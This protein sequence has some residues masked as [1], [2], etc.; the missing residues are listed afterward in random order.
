MP[1]V[2]AFLML[3]LLACLVGGGASA[4]AQSSPGEQ[5][6]AAGAETLAADAQEET[7]RELAPHERQLA[8]IVYGILSFSHWPQPMPHRVLCVLGSTSYSPI[9]AAEPARQQTPAW[10]VRAVRSPAANDLLYQTCDAMY[11]GALPD[12]ENRALWLQMQGRPVVTIKE[13]S[14]YCDEGALFCLYFHEDG[15]IGFQ[16]NLDAVARSGIRVD[17]Q[18]LKLAR[19][20]LGDAP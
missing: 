12:A 1:L 18:V 8:R 14:A 4:R 5:T 13:Q 10:T 16:V 3:M 17:P 15:R 20:P 11:V 2:P 9:L 19:E 6:R 7:P